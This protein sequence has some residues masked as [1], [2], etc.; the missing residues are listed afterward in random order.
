MKSFTEISWHNFPQ[1]RISKIK[2]E[3]LSKGKNYILQID[4]N[5]FIEYLVD[6]YRLEPLNILFKTESV[7]EPKKTTERLTNP[8][9]ETY[10]AEVFNFTVTYQ[11]TGSSELFQVVPNPR[12][13]NSYE[14][15]VKNQSVSFSFSIYRQDVEE[16]KKRKSAVYDQAFYNLDLVNNNLQE[17]SNSY[18]QDVKSL[19]LCEKNKYKEENS[20]FTAINVKVNKDTTSV[21][22]APTIIKKIIPQPKVSKN[23]EFASEPMMS[24]LMYDDIL[25]VIYDLGKSM[26]KKPS[27]YQNKDEE[28]LR[29]QILLFLETRYD[30]TTATGETFN[31]GGKTDIIL[32]YANDNSNLFVAECKIW[33][34]NVEFLKA[35]SQLFDRYLTWRDSK[36]SLILFVTNKDFSNVLNTIKTE[37]K[38]HPY[39][40]KEN[41][42]RGESSFS[43][44]FRLPQDENKNVFLEIIAFHYDK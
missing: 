32:K 25:K 44:I 24:T 26:E 28:S 29:D 8:W 16:F 35:I 33:H 11:F 37:V 13:Y 22:T 15:S 43:Y 36:V 40:V 7:S 30:G 4:E 17:I 23:S 20:F 34:G 2:E 12:S 42:T 19:F 39:F 18:K 41:G 10:N 1:K 27:T 5:E 6:K 3:I 9:G 31:R 38:T 14:I 21:F